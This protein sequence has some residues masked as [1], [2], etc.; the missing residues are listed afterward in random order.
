MA[1]IAEK[2]VGMGFLKVI[3]ADLLARNLRRNG[4]NW[5]A[6]A[7]AVVEPVDQV[8]IARPANFRRKP[9]VRPSSGLGRLR[10][11]PPSLRDARQSTQS[12]CSGEFA[13]EGR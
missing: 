11:M 12:S 3:A 1:A 4:Q 13:R 5:H 6:A 9:P 7:L 8:H 10:Q 2:L